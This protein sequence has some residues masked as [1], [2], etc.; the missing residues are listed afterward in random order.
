M[1]IHYWRLVPVAVVIGALSVTLA[2]PAASAETV[3][4]GVWTEAAGAVVCVTHRTE[5]KP[6]AAVNVGARVLD[7]P[8][9]THHER[10]P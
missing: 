7:L 10:L 1:P 6:V 3:C 8:P 4:P 2:V 9:V 5:P